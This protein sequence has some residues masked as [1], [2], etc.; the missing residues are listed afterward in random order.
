MN[1]NYQ[2]KTETGLSPEK[3]KSAKK[4]KKK[5]TKAKPKIGRDA[6]TSDLKTIK[7]PIKS[8]E[9]YEVPNRIADLNTLSKKAMEAALA[10]SIKDMM[11]SPRASNKQKATPNIPSISQR[12]LSPVSPMDKI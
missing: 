1:P 4:K 6:S 8:K 5:T 3:P 11:K 12:P 2:V 9:K 7:T 10:K